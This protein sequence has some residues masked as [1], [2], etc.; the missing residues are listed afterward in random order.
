MLQLFFWRKKYFYLS[1][2][3]FAVHFHAFLWIMCSLL[4]IFDILLPNWELPEWLNLLFF[5]LPGVYL[6]LALYRFYR[7]K[8]KWTA[9]WKAVVVTL[10]YAILIIA[11]LAGVILL[12]AKIMGIEG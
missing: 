6:M 3:T 4:L 7:P 8:R 2:L 9:I 11:F 5:L 12:V 10:L 1:H